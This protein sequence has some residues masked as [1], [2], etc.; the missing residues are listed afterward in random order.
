LRRDDAISQVDG[1]LTLNPQLVWVD[2]WAL[3]HRL[4]EAE[5]AFSNAGEARRGL[6]HDM[7]EGVLRLYH[8]HFLDGESDVSWAVAIRD[9]LRSRF[10]RVLY[11]IGDQYEAGGR[12]EEASELYQRGL[13]LDNLAE[14]LYRRLIVTY[15]KRGQL[16]GA[17]E[18]YRRCRQM[19]S[20]VLGVQPSASVEALYQ[21]LK[22]R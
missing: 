10:L 5:D 2:A 18:V 14:E 9:K 15:Q 20:V 13:E 6:T 12:W 16:A 11:L 17:L 8:G 1:R 3:E 21:S 19:L 4:G 22:G 7:A